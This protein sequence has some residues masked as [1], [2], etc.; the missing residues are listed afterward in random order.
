MGPMRPV[1]GQKN[2]HRR[3]VSL[4]VVAD[5]GDGAEVLP[6]PAQ[7][8]GRQGRQAGPVRRAVRDRKAL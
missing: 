2:T 7:V 3:P 4:A 6:K 8:L 5:V 1:Y